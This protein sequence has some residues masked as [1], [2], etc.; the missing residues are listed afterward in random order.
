MNLFL[1]IVKHYYELTPPE[2]TSNHTILPPK[3]V[4][5]LGPVSVLLFSFPGEHSRNTLFRNLGMG[6]SHLYIDAYGRLFSCGADGSL[7]VECLTFFEGIAFPF[8]D[9]TCLKFILKTNHP[10]P[11]GP[12]A[13]SRPQHEHRLQSLGAFRR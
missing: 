8:D 11:T 3:Q 10:L 2:P 13:Q 1:L 9:V 7:K 4:W 5:S 6:V 12:S